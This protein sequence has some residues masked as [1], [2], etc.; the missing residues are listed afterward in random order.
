M[1][2][3]S[4]ILFRNFSEVLISIRRRLTFE[5]FLTNEEGLWQYF[6]CAQRP[7]NIHGVESFYSYPGICKSQNGL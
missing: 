5:L 1:K 7:S 6:V 3:L 2:Y 4:E